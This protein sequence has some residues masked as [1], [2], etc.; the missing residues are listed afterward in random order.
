[1]CGTFIGKMKYRIFPTEINFEMGIRKNQQIKKTQTHTRIQDKHKSK[2]RKINSKF[3]RK[4]FF[5]FTQKCLNDKVCV[6]SNFFF[7]LI[8]NVHHHRF[9]HVLT[10]KKKQRK[11]N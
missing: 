9:I 8:P 6:L 4:F 5:C 1:M 11:C 2:A 3:Y 7:H 10:S